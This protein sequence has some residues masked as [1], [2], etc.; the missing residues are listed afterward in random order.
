MTEARELTPAELEAITGAFGCNLEPVRE[1]VPL[2]Q[3]W[4]EFYKA[5]GFKDGVPK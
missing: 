3:L 2:A 1:G 5:A 4:D